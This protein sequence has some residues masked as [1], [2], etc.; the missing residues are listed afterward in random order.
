[1]TI[2][3]VPQPVFCQRR[4]GPGCRVDAS[5]PI[6]AEAGTRPEA[7]VLANQLRRVFGRR[8]VVLNEA[9]P[10][11]VAI[12]FSCDENDLGDEGYRLTVHANGITIRSERPAGVFHGTQTLL[13]L[14]PQTAPGGAEI[15]ALEIEDRPRFSWRGAMLDPA[16]HFIPMDE[17]LR[18]IDVMARHHLNRLHLHLTDDQGWRIAIRRYPLLTE[19]GAWRRETLNSIGPNGERRYDGVPHGGFYSQD[20]IRRIVAWAA[21]RH[22]TVIPEIDLPG[23]M[24]A[25]IAAYPWLGNDGKPCEVLPH[26]GVNPHILNAE[27]RTLR[28]CEDVLIEVMELFPSPWIHVGGDEAVKQEWTASPRIQERIRE[29]GAHDEHGLQSHII[30][31]MDTFLTARG[32]RLIG[33]DEI[34]D[35]GLAPNATVMSWRGFAGGIAAARQGHP[36][37]MTPTSHTYFDYPQREDATPEQIAAGGVIPLERVYAFEPVPEDLSPAEATLVLGGQGQLWAEGIPD[38]ATLDRQAWPRLCALA[39]ALWSPRAQRDWND[40]KRRMVIHRQR[41][42]ALGVHCWMPPEN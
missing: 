17:V 4:E 30:T 25:A 26:W 9:A 39:E 12:R 42:T 19:V 3:L 41:L 8:P 11:L 2:A 1:M 34:L 5:I 35:G 29:L 16:R 40:F 23:H 22:V 14:L 21:E 18:F 36:V 6:V 13:Q 10:E 32:R 38:G 20:D 28:F 37:V 15:P 33:W 24:Q 27:E 7:E 31:R